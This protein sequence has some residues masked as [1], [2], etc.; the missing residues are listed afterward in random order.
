MASKNSLK[1]ILN[2]LNSRINE[3][4][5][6]YSLKRRAKITSK[7]KLNKK[8]DIKRWENSRELHDNWDDRTRILANF[9][10]PNA[11]IIEF[12]AGK[13]SL[14][15]FLPPKCEYNSSDI[16]KRYPDTIV[17]DLNENI[18]F[19]LETFDTA[20]FS[21]VLEYVYSID[22][23]FQQLSGKIENVVLS[24]A[25][26]N[27]SGANRLK[28]GWLSDYTKNDLEDIFKK[29][30]Y[31]VEDYKEWHNQSIYKLTKNPNADYR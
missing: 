6:N 18:N 2:I 22:N 4:I 14:V 19:S 23:L 5:L 26:S 28:Q 3:V 13:K 31:N 7:L 24:Y 21:G 11:R 9:I 12:G 8:S 16:F 1:R 17:C 15:K 30:D 29:H 20:I 10:K 25:C 27:I